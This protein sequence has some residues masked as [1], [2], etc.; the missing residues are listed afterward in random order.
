MNLTQINGYDVLY[1][2]NDDYWQTPVITEKQLFKN[3]FTNNLIPYNYIGFPWASYIDNKYT[4][5]F[6]ELQTAIDNETTEHKYININKDYFTV[7]QHIQFR[8]YI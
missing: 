4:E 2:D 7:A 1:F 8:V 5:R 6:N 3:L